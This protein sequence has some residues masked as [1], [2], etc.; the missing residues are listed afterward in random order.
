MSLSSSNELR[1]LKEIFSNWTENVTG[2]I[3][4]ISQDKN[5]VK[6]K[7]VGAQY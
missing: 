6:E 7:Y 5:E 3:F 1:M 4:Q 2:K